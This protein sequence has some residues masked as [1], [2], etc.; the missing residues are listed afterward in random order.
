MNGPFKLA[1]LGLTRIV[2]ALLF[3]LPAL[4]AHAQ[5]GSTPL[6][7]E[8]RSA[9]N[10]IYLFGTIHVGARKM[11][12]LSITVEQAFAASAV[13]ALEAD[14]TDPSTAIDAMAN[15]TYK[16][17]D[18]L[19]RHISPELMTQVEKVLPQVGLPIEYAR[20]MRPALLAITIAM[21]EIGRQ[22][23]DPGLGLDVHFAQLAKRQGKRI[24]ELESL[25]D[26]L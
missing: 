20:A 13:L 4:T 14:P 3:C 18:N 16:P 15:A 25:A 21:M 17:P 5:D 19:A 10:T 11:Y 23:Y 9:T 8:A 7:W 12:T 26:Q 24:V 1:F 22:G 2:C 6:I